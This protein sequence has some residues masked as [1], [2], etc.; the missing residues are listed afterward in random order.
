M[1]PSAT[2]HEDAVWPLELKPVVWLGEDDGRAALLANGVVQSI[3]PRDGDQRGGYWAAMLP[4]DRPSR[5]LILGLGGGTIAYLLA[6]R[7]GSGAAADRA[8]PLRIVGVDDSAT[9]LDTARA[10]GW[11]DVP[12]LEVV[13]ADAFAYVRDGQERFDYIALDL[14]RGGHFVGRGLTKSFLRQLRDLLDPP[15]RLAV[16]LF[17][18]QRTARRVEQIARLFQVER[19]VTVGSNVIVHA[20]KR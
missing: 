5:C 9:V 2:P 19:Q 13:Q 1:R 7:W 18:D 15:G 10:A 14:Y 4:L 17:R 6:Q 11:L 8:R 20:H 16:N 3:S 12:G